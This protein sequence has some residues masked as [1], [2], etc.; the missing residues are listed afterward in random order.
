MR[1]H[2]LALFGSVG[3]SQRTSQ[4]RARPSRYRLM[5]R[6]RFDRD[7]EKKAMK[8]E[9]NR[10]RMKEKESA[11]ARERACERNRDWTEAWRES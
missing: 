4:A 1:Q 7:I 10:E 9:V 5:G 6:R 11:R 8:K 3:Y 2:M